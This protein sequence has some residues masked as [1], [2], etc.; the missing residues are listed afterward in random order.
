MQEKA[1]K[2][3]GFIDCNELSAGVVYGIHRFGSNLGTAEKFVGWLKNRNHIY[4]QM[5]SRCHVGSLEFSACWLD[6][7]QA[8]PDGFSELQEE[9]KDSCLKN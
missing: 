8:D 1:A 4:G 7:A 2:Q 6:I 9:Y 5:L 3:P